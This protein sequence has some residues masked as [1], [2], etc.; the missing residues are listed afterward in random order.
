M[1][2]MAT[3]Q[4]RAGTSTGTS[5]H[6]DTSRK[7]VRNH[8][9]GTIHCHHQRR[10]RYS[11]PEPVHGTLLRNKKRRP[12]YPSQLPSNQDADDQPAAT[13]ILAEPARI[14]AG[15]TRKA[16]RRLQPDHHHD[17]GKRVET[18]T[19]GISTATQCRARRRGLLRVT[20]STVCRTIMTRRR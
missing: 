19:Q 2:E 5:R 12:A 16:D 3:H 9:N 8:G 14:H 7:E 15:R 20:P 1:L 13:Q 10:K 4:E 17:V 11:D 18:S 6:H